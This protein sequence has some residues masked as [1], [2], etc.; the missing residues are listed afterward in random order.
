MGSSSC[1][2]CSY[3]EEN[4]SEMIYRWSILL[5]WG[6]DCSQK[7]PSLT[8]RGQ[9]RAFI[10]A[11]LKGQ[12]GWIK[13][14]KFSEY[15]ELPYSRGRHGARLA[16]C[17]KPV[18]AEVC[19]RVSTSEEERTFLKGRIRHLQRKPTLTS[20]NKWTVTVWTLSEVLGTSNE[21]R[22]TESWKFSK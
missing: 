17:L 18:I 15:N 21:D 3:W 2:Y 16:R 5:K 22:R 20:K 11:A 12:N 4:K 13:S 10:S 8:C 9:L 14:T 6:H 7:A 19:G 1:S